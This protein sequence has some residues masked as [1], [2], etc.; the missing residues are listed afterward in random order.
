MYSCKFPSFASSL[1]ARRVGEA[2]RRFNLLRP[3][4]VRKRDIVQSLIAHQ[5]KE[6]DTKDLRL[7]L[8]DVQD[9]LMSMLDDVESAKDTLS[10]LN[11]MYLAKYVSP[12]LPSNPEECQSMS[13][14]LVMR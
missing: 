14:R 9:H 4:I 13:T 6:V 12:F 1:I 2:R 5:F 7:Y 11:S 3:L 8:S 10:S